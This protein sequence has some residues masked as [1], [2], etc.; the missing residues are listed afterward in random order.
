VRFLGAVRDMQRFY[1]TIDCLV[2]PP[3]TEAFGL[4]AIEAAALG[5][6]VV[7]AAVDGLPEAVTE[8]VSGFCVQ[9]TLPLG[10]YERLGGSRAGLPPLVYDPLR[11]SL[12]E[13]P[14]ADPSALAAAVERVFS[15]AAGFEALSASA[16][17]HVVHAPG[18]D[19]HVRD[20]AAVIDARLGAH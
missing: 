17:E 5:C 3:L 19:E 10:D 20:V 9:P 11:D 7:A 14:I 12:V 8:G 2:H 16:S 4:V 13:P 6:P 18:F 1:R 15:S